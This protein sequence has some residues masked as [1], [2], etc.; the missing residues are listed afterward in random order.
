MVD[1]LWTS[2]V[3]LS[4]SLNVK[5]L[6]S[7]AYTNNGDVLVTWQEWNINNSQRFDVVGKFRNGT[8][9]PWG[10]LE[11]FSDASNHAGF[12]QVAMDSSVDAIVYWRQATGTFVANEANN[13]VGELNVR[14]RNY[15]G[16][17]ENIVTVS[18]EGEDSLNAATESTEPRIVFEDGRAAVTWWGVNG[19]HNVVYASIM[20]NKT[21]WNTTALTDNGKNSD[22]SS[23]SM[24]NN[25]FIAVA[26]QRTDGLHQRIQSKFY[27][28]STSS[29]SAVMTLSD[30]GSDAIQ[31]D[32]AADDTYSATASWVRWNAA[33]KK[34]VPEIKQYTPIVITLLGENPVTLEAGTSYEESGATAINSSGLDVSAN[35]QMTGTVNASVVGTYTLNYNAT[36][37]EGTVAL[38]ITRTVHVVD[39]NLPIITLVGDTSITVEGGTAYKDAGATASD[40]NDGNI[41]PSSIAVTS[42]ETLQI[43]VITQ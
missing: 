28:A 15:D 37:S 43:L 7:I 13:P 33:E 21:T 32:I 30:A 38:T 39:T 20:A 40:T 31:A 16:T 18:P 11:T 5:E 26:W 35:I 10:A 6:P 29:W 14:Y 19:G 1:G 25:G 36:D 3:T 23:I 41:S 9:Q 22:L 12:S 24:G 2:E 17:L 4:N 8:T 34:Y 42:T 27:N